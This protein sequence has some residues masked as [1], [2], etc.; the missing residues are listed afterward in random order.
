M[1]FLTNRFV[2]VTSDATWK[3]IAQKNYELDER[4]RLLLIDNDILQRNNDDLG[5]F[6]F[7]FLRLCM[8]VDCLTTEFGLCFCLCLMTVR[9][10][11]LVCREQSRKI[12]D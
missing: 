9:Y 6:Y 3:R 1:L 7:R 2:S 5:E 10:H 12:T 11:S 8:Y 4:N